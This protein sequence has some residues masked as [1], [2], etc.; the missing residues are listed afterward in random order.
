MNE[1][2]PFERSPHSQTAVPIT[3]Q[4]DADQAPRSPA[5]SLSGNWLPVLIIGLC[6][7][8]AFFRIGIGVGKRSRR[9]YD[10]IQTLERIWQMSSNRS[11]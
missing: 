5:D 11:D 1:S 6:I 3:Q 10:L 2:S 9:D 8:I 4:S 7:A